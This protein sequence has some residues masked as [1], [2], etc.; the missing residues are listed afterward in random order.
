MMMLLR[1]LLQC[2]FILT[3]TG[4]A[5]SNDPVNQSVSDAT[6][7]ATIGREDPER[8]HDL[9]VALSFSGGGMRAAAFSYGVLAE[10]DRTRVPSGRAQV[11]LLDRLDFVSGVSGGSVTAAY[12]GLK[13]RAALEDFREKFLLR[14]AEAALDTGLSPVSLSRAV[15]GGINDSTQLPRWLDDNLFHGATLREFR[16]TRRPRV[17]INASDIYNRTPFVFGA[18]AFRAICSDLDAYPVSQAVAASAAVPVVFA[19]VVIKTFP[20]SCD[21]KLPEWIERAHRN[22]QAPPMLKAFADAIVR[23]HSGEMPYIKLLDGG[24]VDN[25]GI[26]GFTIARLSSDTPYGPLTP[27][28]AVSLRRMLFLVVDAGRG[29][30]GNWVN[31]VE[32]P[33]GA[34]L[35]LAAADT[36]IDASVRAGFTAFQS[37]LAEWQGSLV[38]WRCALGPAGRGRL[39]VP[40]GWN[41]RDLKLFVGRV[42]FDEL[43]VERAARLA[44]IPTRFVLPAEDVDALIA[45]GG[46]ALREHQSFKAFLASLR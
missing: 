43:G 2:A 6:A 35:V 23:Y 40:P 28:Q 1:R 12:Y 14:N 41:C 45:A 8:A 5:I 13:K 18:T 19:P 10:V 31:T 37:V 3:L 15:A 46:D 11:S 44:G 17:W 36:A 25:F 4:C 38:R 9:L 21:S 16:E 32:G 30:A 7:A 34:D 26:D 24:L 29:P 42:T 33:G 27:K 22:A 39:N 20:Q